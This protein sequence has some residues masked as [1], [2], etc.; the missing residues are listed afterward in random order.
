MNRD[1]QLARLREPGVTWDILVIG[2]GATGIGIAVDAA[3]RGYRTCLVEQGDFGMGTSSR[4]TKLIHG[5][6]R[7]LRQGNIGLVREALRE[8]G[9]LR[10]NAPHLVRELGFVIPSYG[11]W[12]KAYYGAGLRL[13]DL[14]AGGSKFP[15]SRSLSKADALDL[16][17]TLRA[18][19][20]RGGLLYYDGQFDDARLL[21][22]LAQTAV[23]HGACLVNYAAA[24]GITKDAQGRATG[25]CVR[26][27]E[28]GDEVEVYAKVVVNAAGPFIDEVRRQDQPGVEGLVAPSQGVHLVLD[29]AFLPGHTAIVVPRTP[30]GRVMFAIPWLGHT[31]VGTTDT[32]IDAPVR[33]P[34]PRET[35]VESIIETVSR[36]LAGPPSRSDIRSVFTGIRPLVKKGVG[37]ATAALSRE[38][39]IYVSAS[40][41]V[42]IAGG[43]WTTY[44]V[45][46][47]DCVDQAAKV[48]GLPVRECVTEDLRLHGRPGEPAHASATAA[49][50]SEAAAVE[51]LIRETPGWD[52][53]GGG[54][55]PHLGEVIWAVREEMARTVEDVLARRSR[56]L[57][58]DA[59]A[60]VAM[61]PAVAA[62]MAR[63]LGRDATWETNQVHNFQSVAAAYMPGVTG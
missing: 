4:S 12:D 11:R 33:Q 62:V 63:E 42:S 57:F 38:H 1:E 19:G 18:D 31:L 35:E 17:P 13:Y 40:G 34:R 23:D 56:L 36:Y 52:V 61:A 50:G 48:G 47:R 6:V 10:R 49:Y 46:A 60:A 43:K 16:A 26:D 32:P 41:L 59:R 51:A 44:R 8:R 30:D 53:P 54:A 14:L 7:Y 15:R 55:A 37:G 24:A 9:I 27:E 22:S 3:S 28:T 25:A 58:L 5:G 21:I 2:G 39:S 20:L 45:M 29:R